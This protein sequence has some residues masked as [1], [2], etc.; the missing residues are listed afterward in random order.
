LVGKA[1]YSTICSLLFQVKQTAPFEFRQEM[2]HG[3]WNAWGNINPL[4]PL[5]I[6]YYYGF[7]LIRLMQVM[8]AYG[9]RGLFRAQ[10]SFSQSIPLQPQKLPHNAL[11]TRQTNLTCLCLAA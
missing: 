6:R 1:H 7:V 10:G 5:L 9:F 2:L 3:I 8:G 4:T 11:P